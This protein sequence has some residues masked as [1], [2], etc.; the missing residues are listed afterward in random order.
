MGSKICFPFCFSK[1]APSR[2]L[3]L[4]KIDNAISKRSRVVQAQLVPRGLRVD[5]I[6]NKCNRRLCRLG[7]P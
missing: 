7:L 6:A 5:G 3:S 1:A 2:I 4:L